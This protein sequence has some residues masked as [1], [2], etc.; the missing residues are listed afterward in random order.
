MMHRYQSL[1]LHDGHAFVPTMGKAPS[2]LLR[3]I[4]PVAILE[5]TQVALTDVL[6]K[7]LSTAPHPVREW[8]RG[9][10]PMKSVVQVAAKSRSWLA[11]ARHSLRF[12]LI[13]T[14]EFW[15]VSVGEGPTPADVEQKRLAPSSVPSD[16]AAAVLEIAQRRPI[17]QKDPRGRRTRS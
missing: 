15:E 10:P 9:E 6:A 5:P 11:F 12:A 3:E 17:W 1:A 2:G 8:Y 16:L 14:D 7:R 4:D 13:E